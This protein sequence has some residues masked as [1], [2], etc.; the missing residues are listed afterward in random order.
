[1]IT[2]ITATSCDSPW[3]TAS[4]ASRGFG[5]VFAF[6]VQFSLSH[7]CAALA[8]DLAALIKDQNN[9]P[10]A[11]AVVLMS[12]IDRGRIPSAKPGIEVV[13]Q[14]DKEFVPYVKAIP[15][16]SAV[17]FPNKDN[18][19]HH[20]YSF[21]PAKKFELP[22]YAGTPAAPVVFD[23]PGV[24]TLGCN[25]HDWMI[26]FIYVADT[27]YFGKSAAD[28]MVRTGNLPPGEYAVRVWHPRLMVSEESTSRRVNVEKTGTLELSWQLRV[29]PE[30]RPRRSPVQGRGAYR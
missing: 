6:F 12:P 26:G 2:I 21:S 27:P 10:L 5:P 9:Q 22:L 11:D 23:K 16:G 14:V 20:V 28:G 3:R 15:V 17:S 18:I 13:D 24:V 1:M 25:I 8:G 19:R 7:S 4:K 29:K 30:F